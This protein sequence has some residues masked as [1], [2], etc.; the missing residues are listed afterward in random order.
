PSRGAPHSPPSFPTRRSSDLVPR[1]HHDQVAV[2]R[3]AA[4]GQPSADQQQRGGQHQDAAPASA[5]LGSWIAVSGPVLHEHVFV[6]EASTKDRKS[7]RL[8][9]SHGSISYAVF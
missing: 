6:Y 9:S 5:P 8:N 3:S 7:T 4:V 2:A 1:S